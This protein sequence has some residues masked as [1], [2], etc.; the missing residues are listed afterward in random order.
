MK[1]TKTGILGLNVLLAVR[2]AAVSTTLIINGTV[3]LGT[4]MW[5]LQKQ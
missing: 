1:K 2:F 3:I 4:N 5:Y